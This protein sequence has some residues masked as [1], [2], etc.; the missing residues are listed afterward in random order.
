MLNYYTVGRLLL[1]AVFLCERKNKMKKSR[2][3]IVTIV[4]VG[5]IFCVCLVGLIL[6]S[7]RA[8][9]INRKSDFTTELFGKNI[10]VFSPEDDPQKINDLI[11]NIYKKQESNQFGSDRYAFFFLPGKYSDNIILKDGFYTEFCGLGQKPTDTSVGK[12]YTDARWLSTDSDNH[13]GTQN[14]WRGVTNL[15]IE[16]NSLFAVSQA[17]FLRRIK[18]DKNLAL[19]DEGGWV[20]GG[21]IADC[22]SDG[23]IDSGSQQQWLTR[24]SAFKNW[25]GTNW[26]MVFLGDEEGADP[27]ESWPA[28]SYTSVKSPRTVRE[29]PYLWYDKNKKD[30]LVTIPGAEEDVTGASW[31]CLRDVSYE[32]E[33]AEKRNIPLS[34]FYIAKEGKCSAHDINMAL[35]EG[36]N[37]FFTPGI[38]ELD[39]P[40]EITRADTIL[41]GCGLTTLKPVKGTEAIRTSSVPGVVISGILIDA[42]LNKSENLMIIGEDSSAFND[43]LLSD[44][45]TLSD[46]FFRVGG[47][48]ERASAGTCLTVNADGTI[49]DNLWIW[50]ADHGDGVGWDT[51]PAETGIVIKGNYVNAYGLFVEHFEK[52]QTIW[53]GNDGLLVMY[54]SE[55]PYDVPEPSA[56]RS[57]GGEKSGYASIKIDDVTDWQ[58][59]GIGIYSYNRDC[60]VEEVS[61]IELPEEAE[62]VTIRNVLTVM[63]SGNPGISNIINETGGHV[64]HAGDVARLLHWPIRSDADRQ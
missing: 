28:K 27:E 56:W 16:D 58:G 29:K 41:F 23:I 47:A 6:Y 44:P 46:V 4:F 49:L 3:K 63:L 17:T 19:H 60:K 37:I 61:A 32:R 34:D 40:L 2:G 62:N 25:A 14:F 31:G 12:L 39:E 10:Y 24:N 42:C 7:H 54:Q 50:R 36:R 33:H 38:Y 52:Y 35:S 53:K 48:S 5:I 15:E 8:T 51:N 30:F 45:I 22:I 43:E 11:D 20:S 1:P 59:Y 57:H 9:G 18:F 26:N 64:Y 21:F 55:L 13:N